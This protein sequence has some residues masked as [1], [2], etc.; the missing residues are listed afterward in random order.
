[1]VI[2][3]RCLS[4]SFV[5]SLSLSLLPDDSDEPSFFMVYL[6]SLSPSLSEVG[7]YIYIYIYMVVGLVYR[8]FLH[9]K[10]R[11]SWGRRTERTAR[12]GRK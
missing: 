3:L 10:E 11:K 2:A 4:L 7:V 8:C 5:L 12:E 9:D 6:A 1:M